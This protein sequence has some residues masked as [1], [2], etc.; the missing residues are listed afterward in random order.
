MHA[1]AICSTEPGKKGANKKKR[2]G[3]R[4]RTTNIWSTD[5]WELTLSSGPQGQ[6][7]RPE[8]S[9]R[10][11][12]AKVPSQNTHRVTMGSSIRLF[13]LISTVLPYAHDA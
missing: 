9:K 11:P 5:Q 13:R 3:R 12:P 1:L 4:Q 7:P 8:H 6:E 10:Q 2:K